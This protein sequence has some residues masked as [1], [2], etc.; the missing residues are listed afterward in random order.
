[1]T[2]MTVRLP[3]GTTTRAPGHGEL[4]ER[5]RHGVGKRRAHRSGHSDFALAAHRVAYSSSRAN[6]RGAV[7][8]ETLD[9]VRRYG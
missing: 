5:I 8:W 9:L 4:F 1:M 3:N 2:P 6:R 7:H